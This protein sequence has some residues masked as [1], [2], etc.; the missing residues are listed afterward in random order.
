MKKKRMINE[1]KER[2]REKENRIERYREMGKGERVES[3]NY[4]GV[5]RERQRKIGL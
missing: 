4:D 5:K 2:G 3:K 1:E